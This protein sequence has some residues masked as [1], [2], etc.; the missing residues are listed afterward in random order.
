MC[1]LKWLHLEAAATTT[2]ARSRSRSRNNRCISRSTLSEREGAAVT[3]LVELMTLYLPCKCL[4]KG[5]VISAGGAW[6]ILTHTDTHTQSKVWAQVCHMQLYA[7]P[8]IYINTHEAMLQLGKVIAKCAHFISL[9]RGQSAFA[10]EWKLKWNYWNSLG[11][12]WNTIALSEVYRGTILI[13]ISAW[14]SVLIMM[15]RPLG[16]GLA[17]NLLSFHWITN[18]M[19]LWLH[20]HTHTRSHK[21]V[22]WI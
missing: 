18:L 6:V 10:F 15:Q 20:T 2:T 9:Q 16:G 7:V 13:G 17:N 8:A 4:G 21:N 11:I 5:K 12:I 1:R 22:L 3:I 14:L 19:Q